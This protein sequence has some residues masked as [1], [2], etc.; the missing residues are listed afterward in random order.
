M[1][2]IIYDADVLEGTSYIEILPAKYKDE[3]WTATS[4]FFTEENFGYM[5]P[6]FEKGYEKFDYFALNEIDI[7]TW[8]LI[9]M[10]LEVMKQ[11]LLNKPNP[12][13]I[14]DVLGFPFAYSE[15]EF[16][17]NYDINIKQL[18]LM[19]TGFQSWI[20]EKSLSTK[21]ISVLGM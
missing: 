21:I 20:E 14:K 8:E 9:I 17:E 5:I 10:E 18:I 13:T 2:E 19:I 3:C 7:E 1:I 6:A 15:E 12:H 11:Y 16:K 4:I